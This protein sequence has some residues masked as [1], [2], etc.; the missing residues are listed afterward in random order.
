MKQF[1]LILFTIWLSFSIFADESADPIKLRQAQ[2]ID[3]N[4]AVQL[5]LENNLGLKQKKVSQTSKVFGMATSW[6][7]FM[8]TITMSA[9][10][11]R[12]NLSDDDRTTTTTGYILSD[13]PA[14]A[15]D[16]ANSAIYDYIT[17]YTVDIE[18]YKWGL[19]A[20]FD[21]SFNFNA[22]MVFQ[23]AQTVIDWKSGKISLEK[24]TKELT[25]NV[26]TQYYDLIL[27]QK[28]I[29]LTQK[30]LESARRRMEQANVN[31]LNGSVPRLSK[32]SAEVAYENMKPALIEL[33]NGF[34]L[35]ML[36]FKQLL[37]L[38]EEANIALTSEINTPVPYEINSEVLISKYL[39]KNPDIQEMSMTIMS[40]QNAR[41]MAIGGLTPN[42]SLGYSMDPTFLG[43][44]M[45]DKW[46][47][48]MDTD[49]DGE[50]DDFPWEQ[51]SGM[52]RFTISLPIS[53]WVPFAKE[54][55]DLM[56]AQFQIKET[57]LAMEQLKQGKE[58][59]IK[60][61]ILKLKK[62]METIEALKLTVDMAEEA[63]NLANAAYNEGA[64]ELLE[65]EDEE[66]NLTEARLNLLRAE[67]DYTV[68][69]LELEYLLDMN[70]D[71]I[72]KRTK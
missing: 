50:D 7:I 57:K 63:Y 66:N 62:S 24:A 15:A 48:N 23:A 46:F 42:I 33:E 20:N 58:V 37:G 64:K 55:M 68:A 39:E 65:V 8:P 16:V 56:K 22:A 71:E 67:Y 35:A 14:D 5:A 21:L 38:K 52:F 9:T 28:Q 29:A 11:A 49:S 18:R 72:I 54:Q 40:L 69:I 30:N 19:S 4:D 61:T 12:S 13:N 10:L 36:G 44:P 43:D 70:I 6:N 27:M 26:Q 3:I 32:L 2:P 59:E 60:S 45:D 17:P 41:N 31:Y 53:S 1:Y 51:Q 47:E 34:L 25:K